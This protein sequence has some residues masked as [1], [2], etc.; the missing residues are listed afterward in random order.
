[1]CCAKLIISSDMNTRTFCIPI[2][3]SGIPMPAKTIYTSV[4]SAKG[5]LLRH[6]MNLTQQRTNKNSLFMTFYSHKSLILHS[7]S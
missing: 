7:L 1:M 5:V 2:S 3:T 4:K 6:K